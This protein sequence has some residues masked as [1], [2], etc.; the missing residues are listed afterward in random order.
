MKAETMNPENVVF[1]ARVLLVEDSPISQIVAKEALTFFGLD[2]DLVSNGRE[3]VEKLSWTRYDLV[4]MD[5]QMPVMDGYEASAEI[6]KM[7]KNQQIE[8]VPVVALTALSSLKER[9]Q[10]FESGVDDYIAKPFQMDELFACLTKWLKEKME[11]RPA[12]MDVKKEETPVKVESKKEACLDETVL[13]RLLELESMSSAGLLKELFQTY[14]TSSQDLVQ[15]LDND[16]T[17]KCFEGIRKKAHS[18]KSSSSH[19]GAVRLAGLFEKLEHAALRQE[20]E[21]V[22]LFFSEIQEE[23][24]S[25]LNEI[26]RRIKE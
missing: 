21:N 6:R 3:A 24:N 19:V 7:E 16:V 9:M 2:V 1:N 12:E 23:Y 11:L 10:I 17:I 14:I 15:K 13:Q 18:L 4:F 26:K 20:A 5:C 22:P 8:K 25:V